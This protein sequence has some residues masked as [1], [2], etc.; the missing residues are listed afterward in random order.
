MGKLQ[1]YDVLYDQIDSLLLVLVYEFSTDFVAKGLV[2]SAS[3]VLRH[4]GTEGRKE[5]R[6]DGRKQGN[7]EPRKEEEA[8]KKGKQGRKKECR[9]KERE[10]Y[11]RIRIVTAMICQRYVYTYSYHTNKEFLRYY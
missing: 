3:R 4:K 7:K 9:H 5:G 1:T 11:H 6:T 8:R 10:G 2:S